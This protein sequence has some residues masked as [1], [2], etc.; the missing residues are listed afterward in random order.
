MRSGEDWRNFGKPAELSR[1]NIIYSRESTYLGT[2]N[3]NCAVKPGSHHTVTCKIIT[4]TIQLPN[5]TA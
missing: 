3:I 1:Y 5:D 2:C 4:D